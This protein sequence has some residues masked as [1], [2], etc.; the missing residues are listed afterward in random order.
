MSSFVR[1]MLQFKND[2]SDIGDVARDM[3]ADRNLKRT[4]CYKSVVKYFDSIGACDRVYRI[5]E[6]AYLLYRSRHIVRR[7]PIE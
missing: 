6:D 1:W 4:I 3:K 7:P 2:N 5:L